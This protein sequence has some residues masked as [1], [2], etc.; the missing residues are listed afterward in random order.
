MVGGK[1]AVFE[2]ASEIFNVFGRVIHVGPH[3][4]GQLVKL[5]NQMILGIT[6]DAVAETLLLYEKKVAPARQK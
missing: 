4:T 5:M 2:R 3:G 6:I 1:P